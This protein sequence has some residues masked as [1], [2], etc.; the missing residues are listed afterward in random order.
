MS[1]TYCDC[2]GSAPWPAMVRLSVGGRNLYARVAAHG[3]RKHREELLETYTEL[4]VNG[5]ALK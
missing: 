4:F 3:K 5:F 1:E 2:T